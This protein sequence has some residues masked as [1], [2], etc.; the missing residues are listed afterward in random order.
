MGFCYP[1]SCKP[2]PLG[3]S[4]VK[5]VGRKGN[6]LYIEDVDI[7]DGT[8]VLDIKPYVPQF[9]V[10]PAYKIGWLEKNVYKLPEKRDDGRFS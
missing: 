10:R 3:M 8:P 4:I 1:G 2:N 7:V 6:V 5:L 9:D